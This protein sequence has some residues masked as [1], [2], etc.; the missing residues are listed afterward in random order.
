MG[1]RPMRCFIGKVSGS[2]PTGPPTV[3]GS[4]SSDL[5][6]S[7]DLQLGEFKM[8]ERS[9]MSTRTLT[10][11]FL[12]AKNLHVSHLQETIRYSVIVYLLPSTLHVK[13]VSHAV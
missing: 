1:S 3:V 6:G 10:T 11:I 13:R 4:F 5:H 9:T 2:T 7:P 8:Q 12:Q